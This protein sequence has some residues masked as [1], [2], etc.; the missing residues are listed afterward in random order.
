MSTEIVF[1]EVISNSASG[2]Q[3]LGTLAGRGYDT[4]K[5]KGGHVKIKVKEPSYLIGIV[6]ITPRVDYCEGNS[7]DWELQTLD[8][9]RKPQLDGI[10]FQDLN[11]SLM[12]WWKAATDAEPE[13]AVGKQ[14][15][16]INYLKIS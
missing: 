13:T 1:Q 5:Q 16:W 7:W 14:P 4:G 10:G 15:A 12:A 11:E 8:D 2:V 3:P 6:S 9:L